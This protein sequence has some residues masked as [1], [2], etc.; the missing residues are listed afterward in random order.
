MS[1]LFRTR[2]LFAVVMI[3]TRSVN[4]TWDLKKSGINKFQQSRGGL[5][6]GFARA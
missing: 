2:S 1:S 5:E 6:F 4:S 3:T